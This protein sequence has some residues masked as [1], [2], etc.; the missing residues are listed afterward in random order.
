M[1]NMF[2]IITIEKFQSINRALGLL[3]N[4]F[5]KGIEL[6]F[7]SLSLSL[8]YSGSSDFIICRFSFWF[9]LSKLIIFFFVYQ[10]KGMR[11]QDQ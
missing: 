9:L 8:A 2:L 5:M 7:K 3:I 1:Q 11:T 4:A 10:I 6:L